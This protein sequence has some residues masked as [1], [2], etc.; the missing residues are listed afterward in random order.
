MNNVN[1]DTISLT[2][3]AGVVLNGILLWFWKPWLGAYGGEKGKNLARKEDLDAIVAE[4]RAVTIAQKGIE[5]KLAEDLWRTQLSVQQI[6]DTYVGIIQLNN[7]I[8]TLFLGTDA[9]F[10]TIEHLGEE[11]QK[12]AWVSLGGLIVEVA[13]K[14][15]E[16]NRLS[17][18]LQIFTHDE[19]TVRAIAQYRA[20]EGVTIQLNRDMVMA[21]VRILGDLTKLAISSARKQLG[22]P[23]CSAI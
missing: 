19:E 20:G 18:I 22:L 21:R 11:E 10:T 15:R 7:E 4:M 3:L 1:W 6:K 8:Q 23:A 5:S 12:K 14:D 13:K 17:A 9:E 2:A 16:L